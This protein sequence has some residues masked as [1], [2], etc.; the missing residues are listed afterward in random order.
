MAPSPRF[1]GIDLGGTKILSLLLD[2]DM[3]VLRSDYRAT[4]AE[5]GPD[6]VVERMVESALAVQGDERAVAVGISTPGPCDPERGVVT[7]APNLPGWRDVPLASLL[8]ERLSLPAWLDND[9]NAAAL[10]EHRLGAGR[11]TRHMIL[12]AIGTGLGGGFVLDGRLY[13]GASGAAGEVGHMLIVPEGPL[14]GCGRRGCLEAVASGRALERE[15]LRLASE[16]PNGLVATLAR[17]EGIEPD[18][19]ILDLAANAGDDAADEAI[20]QAGRYLGE[21]L[22]NLVNL[23]NP[24]AIVIG[25]SV[26]RAGERYLGSASEIMR[27]DAFPQSLADVRLLEA[28][29]GDEAAAIGAALIAREKAG[30]DGSI[31]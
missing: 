12:I 4:E 30:L 7:T 28:E 9:A 27:R 14:C 10:A 11:G 20:R 3:R 22:V 25:G 23:F 18:G 8:A 17:K 31:S 26:R 29:L 13:H 5:L 15:A 16:Q 19:R 2:G 6:A 21:G 1:L 24:E